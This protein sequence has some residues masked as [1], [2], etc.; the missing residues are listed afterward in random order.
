MIALVH[1]RL[2]NQL[3]RIRVIDLLFA[4]GLRHCKWG[5][6]TETALTVKGKINLY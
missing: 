6:I 5:S 4:L 1:A 2:Y 3:L